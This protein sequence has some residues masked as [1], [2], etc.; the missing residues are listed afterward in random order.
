MGS[1]STGPSAAPSPCSTRVLPLF[2]QGRALMPNG[3]AGVLAE[4]MLAPSTAGLPPAALDSLLSDLILARWGT[5]AGDRAPDAASLAR[6]AQR[7]RQV[8][9]NRALGFGPERLLYALN[10]ALP[11]LSPMLAGEAAGT[12]PAVLAALE[13]RAPTLPREALP[14]DRHLAAFLAVQMDGRLDDA[15]AAVAAAPT[16]VA[17]AVAATAVFAELQRV[18]R[19]GPLPGLAALLAAQAE[20]AL[21]E[22][23][24]RS[25]RERAAA[26]LRAVVDS[27]D[28]SRLYAL[29][30]D[31][32]ARARDALGFTQ[33]RREAR[34]AAEAIAR[35][36]QERARREAEARRVGGRVAHGAGLVVLALT[37]LSLSGL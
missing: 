10:P 2:W 36:R 29:F 26:E 33:A 19:S 32:E 15:L 5:V 3:I 34:E 24:E 6:S 1:R 27:G 16:T 22:W 30:A 21:N 25:R 7:Y 13:R 11:C 20:P 14:L 37:L 31:P 35:I 12:V 4:A 9:R 23:R 18:H 8:W 28:L 17:A